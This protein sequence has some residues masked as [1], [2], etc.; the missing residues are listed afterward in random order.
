MGTGSLMAFPGSM[1]GA[2]LAGQMYHFT[3]IIMLLHLVKC[4]LYRDIRR[5]LAVPIAVFIMGNVVGAFAY[6]IPF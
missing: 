1:V 4:L 6:V 3:K 5:L 2:L